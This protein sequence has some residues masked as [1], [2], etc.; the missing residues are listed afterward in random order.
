MKKHILIILL[1]SLFSPYLSQGQEGIPV[2]HDYLSDNLFLLHPSMAGAASCAKI[3][4]TGR[5][6]WFDVEDSPLLQT[7][8]YNTSFGD[9]G[10]NGFGVIIFNDRN[11]YHSQKG[12]QLAYAHH[13]IFG[14]GVYLNKL[15]FGISGNFSQMQLDETSF[16]SNLDPLIAG[17]LQTETYY[18]IDFG[19]SYHLKGLFI[20]AT[21]KNALLTNRDLY[22]NIEDDNQRSYVGSFGY[23]IE[24]NGKLSIEPSFLIQYK[25]YSDEMITDF[26]LKLYYSLPNDNLGYI[27]ASYR[28]DSDDQVSLYE[29][30]SIT[31]IIGVTIDNFTFA[32]TYT[33]DLSEMPLS[34][35]GFH[36]ITLGF[37]FNCKKRLRRMGCP[38]IK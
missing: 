34:N 33:Y 30:K 27:G 19:F 29:Y 18:N 7:F 3:R 25:E 13:L 5:M 8:S 37:N 10:A 38:E 2:Y 24:G 12:V 31:P 9:T 16:N 14:D 4:L 15:S 22:S 6:Q 23:Y 36:Q 20:N 28:K 21:L 35:S 17:N 32:Y 11:G 1:I 26:N